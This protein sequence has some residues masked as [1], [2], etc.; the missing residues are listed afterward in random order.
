MNN[1]EAGPESGVVSDQQQGPRLRW[2][3]WVLGSA[4]L[5]A[6]VA[7]T[8]QLAEEREFARLVQEAQPAWLL[9]AV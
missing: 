9:V 1:M 3:P 2:L 5:A 4:L 6:V 7:A 8:T